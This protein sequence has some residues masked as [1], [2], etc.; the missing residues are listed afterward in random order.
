MLK[1]L[2]PAKVR[3]RVYLGFAL[4]GVGLGGAEAGFAVLGEVPTPLHVA[5]AVYVYVGVATGLLAKAN[6]R[7]E[8]AEDAR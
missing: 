3:S 4:V 8:A 7:S 1:D 6:T 5:T 2:L